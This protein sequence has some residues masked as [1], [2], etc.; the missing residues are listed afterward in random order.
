MNHSSSRQ[1]LHAH[2]QLFW[3]AWQKSQTGRRL[4][5]LEQR[6]V[7]VIAIHPEYHGLFADRERFIDADEWADGGVNPYL[8][9]SLHLALEEQL[10]TSQPPAVV[11]A[12]Q[13]LISIK[14]LERHAALHTL[15]ELLAEMVH[16]AQ[17]SGGEPDVLTYQLRLDEVARG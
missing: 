16:Q 5:D 10:A 4:S 11:A 9:L 7:G 6:I 15:L 14:G 13:R 17:Q 1:Q 3:A 8:H 2:R 12:L